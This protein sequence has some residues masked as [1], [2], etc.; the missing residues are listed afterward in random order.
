MGRGGV[1]GA[2]APQKPCPEL[3]PAH[4]CPPHGQVSKSSPFGQGSPQAVF[5]PET[6]AWGL[7][8]EPPPSSFSFRVK[9]LGFLTEE[10][11]MK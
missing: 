6:G 3:R 10:P 2:V 7:T 9:T 1:Q 11:R 5:I 8:G 4:L